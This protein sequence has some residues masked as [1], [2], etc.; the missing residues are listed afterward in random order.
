MKHSLRNILLM[1]Q[2]RL[3]PLFDFYGQLMMKIY[4]FL[5]LSFSIFFLVPKIVFN[6]IIYGNLLICVTKNKL[7]ENGFLKNSGN[8]NYK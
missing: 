4:F 3:I 5:S 6:V 1:I 2:D 8:I 7:V